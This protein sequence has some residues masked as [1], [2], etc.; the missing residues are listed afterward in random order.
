MDECI[1]LTTINKKANMINS[2]FENLPNLTTKEEPKMNIA[3]FQK[4]RDFVNLDEAG[5]WNETQNLRQKYEES[6]ENLFANLPIESIEQAKFKS[7]EV[8]SKTLNALEKVMDFSEVDPGH[9]LGHLVRD[10]LHAVVLAEGSKMDPKQAYIGIVGGVLH[11]ILGCTLVKRYSESGRAV[12]HAE[13][14]GLL[15]QEISKGIGIDQDEAL[16]IYY[17]I[18]AHTH[19][20]KPSKVKCSDGTER[21][22]QPYRDTN[23]EGKP[24]MSVL[25]TRWA[26]RFDVN[27]PCFIG[28]HFLTLAEEHKDFGAGEYYLIKFFDHMRPLLRNE[29]EIK[30]DPKGRTMREHLAM[31]IKSQSNDSP[32]GK[33]DYGKMV[34]MRDA[35]KAR[36]FRII[37]SFDTPIKLSPE[38]EVLLLSKWTSWLSEKIEPSDVGSYAS[39][40][41][42]ELFFSLPQETKNAW[43][44]AMETTLK[45][46][47]EWANEM[48]K[49]ISKFPEE[50]LVLPILG[51]IRKII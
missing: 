17:A 38:E 47:D 43:F 32:Y 18:A 5:A 31:F 19:Y 50:K 51:D 25:L 37:D 33:F 34:E 1:N 9:G 39:E 40:K 16:L 23:N 7:F 36:A 29:E 8:I 10:Y 26:D 22:I 24:I 45:E 28:R 20:L 49:V 35:Y 13:A 4:I 42:K 30:A 46:Y 3:E 14:G 44:S 11:D 48:M 6:Y 12:R 21:E 41:L 15:F 2:P 27:G